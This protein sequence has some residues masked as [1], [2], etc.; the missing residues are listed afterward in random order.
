[1]ALALSAKATRG[2]SGNKLEH[3][4]KHS[5][6]LIPAEQFLG[7]FSKSEPRVEAAKFR[8]DETVLVVEGFLFGE[9]LP[10]YISLVDPIVVTTRFNCFALSLSVFFGSR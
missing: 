3:K 6:L 2:K 9:K 5:L 7:V 1:M 8:R 10:D 4:R